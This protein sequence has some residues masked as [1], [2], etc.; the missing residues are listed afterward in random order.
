M[1]PHEIPDLPLRR[2]SWV[3]GVS[4]EVARQ[5]LEPVRAR[6]RAVRPEIRAPPDPGAAAQTADVV[7]LILNQALHRKSGLVGEGFP[8]R[9]G[10]PHSRRE[11]Q[12]LQIRALRAQHRDDP[13]QRSAKSVHTLRKET[14][15][16]FAGVGA[17]QPDDLN[18]IRIDSGGGETRVEEVPVGVA[19]FIHRSGIDPALRRV[20]HDHAS[21]VLGETVGF[22]LEAGALL[23]RIGHPEQHEPDEPLGVDAAV[24]GPRRHRRG[25]RQPVDQVITRRSVGAA[26]IETG[27]AQAE[28]RRLQIGQRNVR[29][30]LRRGS[31]RERREERTQ[32][33]RTEAV[34]EYGL[35][36]PFH[37]VCLLSHDDASSR[38]AVDV[39]ACSQTG[40]GVN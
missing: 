22:A 15:G 23:V 31:Q 8:L 2:R 7:E 14:A 38:C 1:L 12:Q 34:R 37:S 26:G 17:F 10:G 33:R 19:R 27:L 6:C 24:V 9:R 16:Q 20:N 21:P 30:R 35:S 13:T 5:P 11:K 28:V 4:L 39:A 25:A 40:Q 29:L 3:D 36:G 32:K 18:L